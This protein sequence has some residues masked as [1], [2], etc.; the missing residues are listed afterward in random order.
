VHLHPGQHAA[1]DV[2]AGI[3]E[4]IDG[5]FE[6][7]DEAGPDQWKS[8]DRSQK[9]E[10]QAARIYFLAAV[11]FAGRGRTTEST[12][13]TENTEKRVGGRQSAAGGA[14]SGA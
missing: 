13:S 7:L 11:S 5:A 12:E 14:K 3:R 4:G 1:K 2:D 10:V 6:A 9:S 8:E